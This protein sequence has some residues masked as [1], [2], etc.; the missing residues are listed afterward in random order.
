MA[1]SSTNTMQFLEELERESF[2]TIKD[3]DAV[4]GKLERFFADGPGKIQIISDFDYTLTKFH[5]DGKMGKSTHGV[6]AECDMLSEEYHRT[7]RALFDRYYPVETNPSMSQAEKVPAMVEWWEADHAAL[8][9]H[10]L[11]RDVL[12]SAVAA[13]G[14]QLRAGCVDLFDWAEGRGVPVLL[15]SAGLGDV[16]TEVLAQNLN[17][18]LPSHVHVISNTMEFDATGKL[19]GFPP[20]LFHV[21]NK[22]AGA[23][24]DHPFFG[25]SVQARKNILLIGDSTGDARMADGLEG[26]TVLRIGFLNTKVEERMD[27]YKGLYDV[28]LTG[29]GGLGP[30][31]GLLAGVAA[32]ATATA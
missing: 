10:G 22:N 3:R 15:F 19:V 14:V 17:K 13:A 29:D 25:E 8:V 26:T 30:L 21:Y 9:E 7:A 18:P 6:L 27:T 5:Y 24:K 23:V 2:V 1:Y 16:L 28:V 32:A 31:L 4:F 11:T 12:R 20:P